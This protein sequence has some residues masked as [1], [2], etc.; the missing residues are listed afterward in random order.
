MTVEPERLK[1]RAL[2]TLQAENVDVYSFFI[3]GGDIT[4]IA[5]ISRLTR[6][7]DGL[8]GFQRR[9]IRSHVK[10]IAAFLANGPVL[11]PNAIILALSPEV[12][13]KQ[14]RGPAP[15]GALDFVQSG[16][17]NIPIRPEG[18]RAAWIVDGQQRS[19]ALAGADLGD[20]TVPVVAFV[21]ADIEVQREQFILVNKAKPLPSR[22]IDELLP[23]VGALLPRDLNSRRLPSELCGLLNR[24][25]KSPFHNLIRR[26]SEPDNPQAVVTDSAIIEAIKS[27]LK[28]PLG[29]LSIYRHGTESDLGGMYRAL[30]LYWSAVR[31][32]FPEAWGKPPTASRLMHSAGIRA[33]GSVMD[34]ILMR[35]DAAQ[36][37]EADIR[38]AIERL[39]PYCRWTA[40]SWDDLEWKWNDIQNTSKHIKSLSEYLVRLDRELSRKSR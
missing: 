15:S 7:D 19:L 27:N 40:G 29:A 35:A 5:D 8:K 26:E 34:Q 37:P 11:F 36:N 30:T 31:D 2:R 9:E 6:G 38:S 39:V 24:E 28:P 33:M 20:V 23:E 17:L 16:I 25:P 18:E 14:S 1:V 22:L 10:D 3:R 4:K 21:S 32:C 13:F 12:D